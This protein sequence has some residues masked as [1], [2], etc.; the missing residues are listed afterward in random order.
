MKKIVKKIIIAICVFALL[1]T[2]DIPVP[3]Y[4]SDAGIHMTMGVGRSAVMIQD[5]SGTRVEQIDAE[6]FLVVPVIENGI[7][8]VPLRYVMETVGFTVDHEASTN[9]IIFHRGANASFPVIVDERNRRN[10]VNATRVAYRENTLTVTV[11]GSTTPIQIEVAPTRNVFN[12]AYMPVQI[13]ERLE[14]FVHLDSFHNTIHIMR[15]N[16]SDFRRISDEMLR[17]NNDAQRTARVASY[18]GRATRNDNAFNRAFGQFVSTGTQFGNHANN[19][20]ALRTPDGLFLSVTASGRHNE[21]GA[22]A[23]GS[24]Q[25]THTTVNNANFIYFVSNATRNMYRVEVLGRNRVGTPTRVALPDRLQESNI[26][27]IMI[28]GEHLFFIAYESA[29]EGGHVYMAQIGNEAQSAVRLTSTRAWNIALTPDNR[30]FYTNFE[31]NYTL[32]EINLADMGKRRNLHQNPNAGL[33]GVQR[34]SAN[35]QSLAISQRTPDVYFY[36]DSVT[37]AIME[38]TIAGGRVTTRELHSPETPQTLF[39]FLNLFDEGRHDFLFFIEYAEGNRRDFSQSRIMSLNLNNNE[40]RE[41]YVSETM[42]MQLTVVDESL[43]F[44]NGDYSRLFRIENITGRN[45]VFRAL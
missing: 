43:Y 14:F 7:K 35:I 32:Y 29:N 11:Q 38:A 10:R 28:N 45:P 15:E 12:R 41:L 26:S 23:L 16:A 17:D 44:T 31:R 20:L 6:N 34:Q 5:S 13:L 18:F 39:N 33:S 36:V 8:Y 42:I 2:G 25:L 24:R 30:L 3:V 22:V 19:S 1:L 21:A 37:G 27:Q 9:T 4:A 40:I